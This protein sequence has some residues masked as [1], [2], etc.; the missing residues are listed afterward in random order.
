MAIKPLSNRQVVSRGKVTRSDHLSFRD[1]TMRTGN[2]SESFRPGKD[3]TKN[4][5]VT[6]KDIDTSVLSH[7][8]NV[9]KP[10]IKEANEIIKGGDPEK[11]IRMQEINEVL[12]T[13]KLST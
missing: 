11:L 6:L 2:R 1:E 4:F 12:S 13:K 7:V 8:K 9:M 10:T 3:F 5:S